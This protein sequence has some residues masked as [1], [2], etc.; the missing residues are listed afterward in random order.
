[1]T[2]SRHASVALLCGLWLAGPGPAQAIELALPAEADLAFEDLAPLGSYRLPVGPYR[3]GAVPSRAFEGQVRQSA[4]HIRQPG[5]ATLELLAPLRDQLAAQG[6]SILYECEAADCGGFDF[7][8]AT[9]TLPE[10]EM[11]V[12]L[13]DY[14]F[15]AAER[16]GEAVGLLISRSST[17]GFVQ[18][19]HVASAGTAAPASPLPQ[20]SPDQTVTAIRPIAAIQAGTSDVIGALQAGGSVILPGVNFASGSGALPEASYPVL[21]DLAAWLQDHPKARIA[22]IGHTDASG[23]L[24]GNIALSRKRAEAVR[25]YLLGQ[26]KIAPA[27]VEAEGV[28]YLAP[29]ASNQSD[30][31]RAQNRRVEV[32]LT[33]T[34]VE[35]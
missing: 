35:P 32:M 31:G 22:I 28:G 17:L 7:R 16:A 2:R 27:R 33:S 4:W 14:R 30:D 34:P 9:P 21:D 11:H 1:M 5:I 20:N 19:A 3:D 18:M 12:D 29:I 26:Q 23:G 6:F 24:E 25:Q 15:L 8:F 10:P 13:G